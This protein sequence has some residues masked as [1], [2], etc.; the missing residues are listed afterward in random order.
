MTADDAYS[1]AQCHRGGLLLTSCSKS[2]NLTIL[3]KRRTLMGVQ[4][5]FCGRGGKEQLPTEIN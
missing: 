3:E 4:W 2:G 5:L 1:L